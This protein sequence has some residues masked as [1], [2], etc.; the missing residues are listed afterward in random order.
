MET[1]VHCTHC[2]LVVPRGLVEP[3]RDEQFCC[4]ACHTAHEAI[5][6][7][8]L[9][10]YYELR[11]KLDAG[12]KP[13]RSTGSRYEEFDAEAFWRVH[14]RVNEE[15]GLASCE[16]YL[17]GVHCA[18]CVWLVE[19][20]PQIVDGL[21]ESRLDLGRSLVRLTWDP[22]R[23][24]L[25]EVAR[26]IDSLGYRSHPPSRGSQRA[27]RRQSDRRA[28]IR[29]GIAGAFA[30]NAM[31]LAVALYAG[32]FE[33]M[34]AGT[35][36]AFRL[37]SGAL[38]ILS[39]FWP[40]RV[41][42]QGALAA[43][44]TRT[45]HLDMPIALA[46]AV[47]LVVGVVNAMRDAGEVYFDSITM[48]VFLLL[49][50]R[51]L[52]QRGQRAAADA[53]ELLFA[54]TPASAHVV[55]DEGVVR[56]EPI[57]GVTSGMHVEVLAGESVPVD[58]VI[59]S[60]TSHM[61]QSVMTGEARP[62]AMA[63]GDR[64]TAGTVNLSAP[65]RVLA[66]AVGDQTRLGQVMRD[67]ER[68]AREQTPVI[69]H[70][71]RIAGAF[72]AAVLGLAG[73]TLAIWLPRGI[74]PAI[75]HATAL[76]IVCCPCALAMATPLVTAVAVGRAARRGVLIKGA[77][78]FEDITT[79][80]LVLLDKT[81]TL[82]R[83]EFRCLRWTGDESVRPVI[84]ALER[85]SQ[86]PIAQTLA[87]CEAETPIEFVEIDHRVGLGAVGVM[88]GERYATGSAALMS[89]I[90][91]SVPS[92]F[93]DYARDAAREG[94]T[95]ILI[96]RDDKVVALA[97]LGDELRPEA[98]GIV[99]RLGAMGWRVG[100][101]SGDR[102]DV[103]DA[104]AARLGIEPGLARGGM[105]PEGKIAAVTEAKAEGPVVMVGDGVNDAAALAKA[106]FG[107]A[108]QG[109]AEASLAAAHAY[110]V[111]DDLGVLPGLL[112]GAGRTVSV[113][114]RSLA[115]SL[116]YNLVAAGLAMAGVLTP[117]VAAFLMPVSSLTVLVIALRARTF[118]AEQ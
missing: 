116:G 78:A 69:G 47:G 2:G 7:C 10:A 41:F 63:Q 106:S 35:K 71:N 45:W 107:V 11:E 117:L 60:G 25:S 99:R 8:G 118:A 83:G 98:E 110:I 111:G 100:I 31:L 43:I 93:A 27:I 55:D 94:H 9:G 53:L 52:Q 19:R 12:S 73:I 51:W 39:V 74:E 14:V 92:E 89:A 105:S 109:G 16:L 22:D 18:A 44:R 95:P 36:M 38:G 13:A 56:D 66:E 67:I 65:V 81:G 5:K 96:A 112:T 17:E 87:E 3:G 80:G 54:L 97:V 104:V 42:F 34:D 57:E 72:V 32:M 114:K 68:H 64:V 113:V 37:I 1:G 85:G 77:G 61:D 103:V 40:G 115:A 4:N 48:L 28:L 91:V 84:A 46:L 30:G 70:A 59:V 108:L 23:V 102:Q 26:A 75:G 6:A 21:I 101:L 88:E 62:V 24:K 29:I 58:G 20:V 15:T 33:G 50:G 49:I 90:G 76:L 82:T 79:P 86:H